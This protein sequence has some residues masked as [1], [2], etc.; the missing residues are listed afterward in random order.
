MQ[1][2]YGSSFDNSVVL[3]PNDQIA[4]SRFLS[5]TYGWMMM[6]LL[7]TAFVSGYIA[8]SENAV[9]WLVQNRWAFTA[10]IF[11]E[12]GVVLGLSFLFARLSPAM[13]TLGFLSYSALNGVTFSV[14]FLV[15]TMS[16]IAQVF[17]I[18]AGMFGGLALFGT[19]TKKNL[20]AAGTFFAMGIW[21]LILLGLVN[22]FV[23]SESLSLGL[24]AA[25]VFV[26]AGLTAYD[27]QRL[28]GMAYASL[29]GSTQERSKGAVF[30]ALMLYLN[31]INLFMSLLRL[32]G[33]RRE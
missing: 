26:F 19:V 12:L 13:A 15:Y 3:S 5:K 23:Q 7:I 20:T 2:R 29:N 14:I 24:A 32:F 30:G 21:G 8:S 4:V 9:Q 27:A 18:T 22:M 28:K 33:S 16:S 25:G 1:T 10:A 6:G 31:F 17:M 11:A